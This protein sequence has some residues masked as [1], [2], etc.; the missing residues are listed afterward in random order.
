M[1]TQLQED[2]DKYLSEEK[3]VRKAMESAEAELSES[4]QRAEELKIENE[5]KMKELVIKVCIYIYMFHYC[6][7]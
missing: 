3:E 5:T 4:R 1:P 6:I 7:Q 2:L